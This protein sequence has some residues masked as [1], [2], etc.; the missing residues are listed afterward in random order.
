MAQTAVCNGH[1]S[2]DQQL[3]RWL[4]L[5]LDRLPSTKLT[6]TQDL[7]ANMLGVRREGVTDAAGKLQKVGVI[8]YKPRTDRS[9]RPPQARTAVLRVLCRGQEGNRQAVAGLTSRERQTL[10]MM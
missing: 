6:I 9:A 2:V 1:H 8:H 3:C 7:I 10:F 5:S 4:L